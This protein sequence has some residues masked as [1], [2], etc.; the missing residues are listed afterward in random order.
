MHFK[1]YWYNYTMRENP[2]FLSSQSNVRILAILILGFGIIN[3]SLTLAQAQQT[4]R[5]EHNGQSL[6][7]S[8]SN[9]AWINF[10]RDI[11]PGT[12]RF[13]QF[14]AMFKELRDSG[15]NSMR[16]WLHTTGSST[17]Q[18]NGSMVTGPGVGAIDDLRS[19]LNLAQEY[20]ISLML[21]LWS[22]DMLR[23]SNGSTVTDRSF[24]I[25]TQDANMQSYM[26][27]SLKP[28][29][30]ALKGHKAILAWEIFNEA[31]GMSTEFGWDGIR[32]VSMANIQ[33]FV[34]RAAGT[35]KRADPNVSV[36]TG[37]W[38]FKALSDVL[39]SGSN[40]STD[41]NY[42]R[43]DRLI[44]RGG[45]AQGTLTF[46]TVH[47]YDWAGTSLSPFHNN[48]SVWK[49][50]KPVVVAEFYAKSDIFGI[51]KEQLFK[52]LYDRGYAGA[53]SWQWVD[54]AQNRE[55]N[56]GSWPVT[57][58]NTR[59]MWNTHGDAVSLSYGDLTADISS[60]KS[61]IETGSGAWIKWV[62]RGASKVRLNNESVYFRDSLFVNPEKTTTYILKAENKKGEVALDS[63]IV[64]VLAPS[65]LNRTIGASAISSI[66]TANNAID[67]NPQTSWTSPGGSD[68]YVYVDLKGSYDISKIVLRWGSKRPTS[69]Q[70]SHS[71]DAVVWSETA[72]VASTPTGDWQR[73]F[74]PIIYTRFLRFLSKDAVD[75]REIEAY[76]T[77][78]SV[79]RFMLDL[80]YPNP[81][82]EFESETKITLSA[83][84]VRRA[85]GPISVRFYA[86]DELIGSKA[87]IP[88]TTIWT[89]TKGGKYTI[90]AQIQDG[91]YQINARPVTVYVVES[92]QKTRYEA[93]TAKLTGTLTVANNAEA[94]E[95]KYVLMENDGTITWDNVNV[96][97]AGKFTLRLGYYLPF[98]YKEQYIKVNTQS[99]FVL[100]FNVPTQ[101]WTFVDT[102]VT[103][104]A[105]KNTVTVNKFWGYMW[106]D[107]LEVRGDNQYATSTETGVDLPSSYHLYP[108][109]PNPFNPS[110]RI[111]Y[112]IP[113]SDD[114]SLTVYDALG[115]RVKTLFEGRVSAGTYELDF[116]AKGLSS[117]VYIY[118][119]R[120]SNTLISQKMI[121]LK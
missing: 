46:Y 79:Q 65:E 78:S 47:Y 30:E 62:A 74:S 58:G 71:F 121:L 2:I 31:E 76:G 111:R 120:S 9:V 36:T 44:E 64:R 105:G 85:G 35:I 55:N 108:N 63:V 45:D 107:Y 68:H 51:K 95:G 41:R 91:T 73:E 50:D 101:E 13:D 22:F 112:S 69:F 10:A 23:I 48:V 84:L 6:F 70:I 28:M 94:S 77:L 38:A 75:L 19:I 18:W 97:Q 99:E 88:Y 86:N 81:N 109:Y 24:A 49:L 12:T 26:D 117:G 52:T 100:P 32:R 20:D 56:A 17:P 102:T 25:L 96:L 5:I 92:V 67:E 29:V 61:A 104:Q 14:E 110:T 16:L 60:S 118:R 119:L 80:T 72:T 27:N 115:R 90:T 113:V 21:C 106:F 15:G 103:L 82:A 4:N 114:I 59:S 3:H 87:T 34:N 37:A 1:K 40:A 83:N 93:E 89:P 39:V 54:W 53:L 57:L 8:G 116:N 66:G 43:D 98:D 7:V 33:K 11:G 42:Y